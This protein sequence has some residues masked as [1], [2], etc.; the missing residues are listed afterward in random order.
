MLRR[1][2]STA[3]V[4]LLALA[5]AFAADFNG[6]WTSEFE[7]QIGHQSYT[8]EFKVSGSTLTGTAKN[9]R[10]TT[11]LKE[12]KVDGDTISFVE[13]V[14][15]QG[16]QLRIEHTGKANGDEI[17]FHRKVADFAEYEIVAKR[18]K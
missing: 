3:A 4:L 10:G 15:A 18:A 12:G 17:R 8:F 9:Q 13:L 1:F 7:S 14:D 5:P 11:E 16:Q 6:K 2:V